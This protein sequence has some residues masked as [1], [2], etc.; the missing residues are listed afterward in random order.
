MVIDMKKYRDVT[1]YIKKLLVSYIIYIYDRK[2][3][4]QM[5]I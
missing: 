3:L 5:R 4:K 2:S 1:I